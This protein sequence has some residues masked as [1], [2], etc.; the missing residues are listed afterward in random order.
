MVRW[1]LK[2]KQVQEF[3]ETEIGKIPSDWDVKK[4]FDIDNTKNSVQ[5]GPFG[6]LL[7]SYDYQT[8]GHP[9]ILVKHVKDG[10]IIE[11]NLPRI[12][13][14]KYSQLSKFMLKEGDIVFTRV[15]YVGNTA[16]VEK[17]H[18]GWL[19]SGQTLRIR[20]N[21]PLINNRFISYFFL[22]ENFKNIASSVVLGSTRDSINTQILKDIPI[23]IPPRD[24]QD[25][26]VSIISSLIKQI[27]CL[28]FQNKVLEQITQAIF[29]SWFHDLFS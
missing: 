15:G 7:H 9:L 28:E 19:F 5:T 26:I 29:K 11:N 25:K 12:G 13:E 1:N 3:K 27:R 18:T 22:T 2:T 20:L 24:E 4:I 17:K 10:Q 6:S 8:N 21:H 16:Y 23:P 14:T